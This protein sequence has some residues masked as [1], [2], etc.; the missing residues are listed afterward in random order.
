MSFGK[1]KKA[2]DTG[3]TLY[4]I[5]SKDLPLTL[6]VHHGLEKAID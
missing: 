3:E 1:L 5:M 6:W 4:K 2:F